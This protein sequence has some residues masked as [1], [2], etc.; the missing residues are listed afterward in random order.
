MTESAGQ[1]LRSVVR[2]STRRP[3]LTVF[4]SLALATAALLYT[5][6]ALM[7]ETSNLRLLP[8]GQRYAALF[9]EYLRDFGE[10]ND[11]V[12]AVEGPSGDE[13]KAYAVRLV[14]ELQHRAAAPPRA[15]FRVDPGYFEGRALLYLSAD[16]L[17]LIRDKILDHQEFIKA[18]A[19]HPTLDQLL[20]GINQQ[21][22]AAFVSRFFDLGLQEGGPGDLRFLQE[23]LTQI[24][25]RAERPAPYRSPWATIFSLGAAGDQ[26]AGYFLSADRSLLFIL[27]EP[28]RR[29]GEF[30]DNR[31]T[32]EALRAIIAELRNDFPRVQ[33]GVTGSPALSND[34]M[35]TAFRDS[36]LAVLLAFATT[37]GLLLLAFRRVGKPILLLA[38]LATSL[39]W[40]LGLITLTVGHLTIFSVMF[41]S[42]VVGIGIDYG[43]YFLFRYE[44]ELSLGWSA[45]RAQEQTATRTGPGIL[46]GALTAAGTFYVLTLTEFRGIQ[47]FG[48][49]SG[50]A[51]LMAFLSMLTFFPALLV[52]VDRR[53]STQPRG[54]R[55]RSDRE[56]EGARVSALELL[57]HYPKTILFTAALATALALVAGRGTAFDYN[58]LNLQA[59]GTESVIWEKKILAKAGRS[60]FNGLATART[61]D[62]LREKHEAFARLPSV[63][64]VDSVLR[65]IPDRQAEKINLIWSF[66]P[67][68]AP[69]RIGTPAVLDLARLRQALETLKR[70][71]DLAVAEAGPDG[72]GKEIRSVQSRVHA[73]LEKLDRADPQVIRPTLSRF[74]TEV[75]RD[76]AAKFRRFQRNLNPRPVTPD[77]APPELR[78]KYVGRSGRFLLRVHPGV[79]VW[80][81][82]GAERFVADL[83]SVDPDVTGAPVITYEAIR[84]MEQAYVRGSIYAFVL[85]AG[86]TALMLRRLRDTMLALTPLALGTLWTVGLMSV[87]GL[88]FNLANVW[89]LPLIIGAAAEYGL[90]AVVRFREARTHG[91]PVLARSTVMA[92]GLNG[93]TTIGGFGSLMVAD[94]RGIFGLGLLLTI[95]ASA[96]LASS[97]V[98]L[99]ALIGLMER[100][101][102]AKA[103]QIAL[104]APTR[105]SDDR[106]SQA[107]RRPER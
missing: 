77:D 79:D 84:L 15:T 4:L 10:L 72:A 19:A 57:A 35:T 44:E 37:L 46:L 16:T 90:N 59:R 96:S 67:L 3:G 11:I 98:V 9:S 78:Q 52:L 74:Q 24:A 76:F 41:I 21:I 101:F 75:Y 106:Y 105:A 49:V 40:S 104:P 55:T 60:G 25:A 100:P 56:L 22:A 58:L 89:G 86:L 99:P 54:Q 50:T 71:I 38:A 8:P 62:E 13:A 94:H 31:D 48:L 36:K 64:N 107:R 92:I 93:L 66:A 82:H 81:R 29:E 53:Y 85:V 88:K 83:R 61:L 32:I 70:R 97:L 18:Y 12:V 28:T 42:I 39:A 17:S 1:L 27:V 6:Q 23:L 68:M 14:G 73:V 103:E 33:A 65:L 80:D 45:R 47:E 43:I 87:F 102:P 2:A 69:V 91:G 34:E 5:L 30:T 95:G 51:I 20:E 26:D 63:S 7:F